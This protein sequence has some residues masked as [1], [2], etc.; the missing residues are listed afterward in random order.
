MIVDRIMGILF[1]DQIDVDLQNSPYRE[2]EIA[3]Y[4]LG[5]AVSG[6]EL[7]N[8]LDTDKLLTSPRMAGFK[9]N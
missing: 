3:N 5:V 7:T 1:L 4:I 6:E 8:I 2:G 9:L